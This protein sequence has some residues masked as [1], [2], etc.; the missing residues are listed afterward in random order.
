[1]WN[2]AAHTTI[3]ADT[4]LAV[5]ARLVTPPADNTAAA[6]NRLDAA[7]ALLVHIGET[8]A[9]LRAA[10]GLDDVNEHEHANR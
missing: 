3:A 6:V 8:A 1:M 4:I 5:L 2:L 10:I 9:T 7:T